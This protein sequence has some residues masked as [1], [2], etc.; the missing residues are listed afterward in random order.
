MVGLY[1]HPF[2]S[3]VWKA[4]IALHEREVPFELLMVDGDHPEHGEALARLTPT[5]Q[6]PVLVDGERVVV[7]SSAV[8]EYLDLHHGEAPPMVPADPREALEARQ[9]DRI[10]DDYVQLPMQTVVLDALRPEGSR[11]PFGV[12]AARRKLD[13]ASGWLDRRMAGRKWAAGVFGL[14][15]CAAAP[16]LFYADWVQPIP[17]AQA[18]LRAYR[19]RLLARPSVA[20]V[21]DAARPYRHFFPPGAPDRD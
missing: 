8:V 1:G 10:F 14:A 13:E 12:E 3:F 16:A 6:F 21:V 20:R 11:D 15:D 5:G 19:T 7:G 17:E 9:M 18:E 2:A 4:L